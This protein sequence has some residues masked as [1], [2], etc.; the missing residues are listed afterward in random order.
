MAVV[1]RRPRP[2]SAKMAGNGRR[3]FGQGGKQGGKKAC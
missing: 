3:S 1:K 2:N